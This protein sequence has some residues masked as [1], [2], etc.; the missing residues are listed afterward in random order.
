MSRQEYLD[1]VFRVLEIFFAFPSGV[2]ITSPLDEVLC[3]AMALSL[4]QYCF[5][6]VFFFAVDY[7]WWWFL[8]SWLL[9][10]RFVWTG[11]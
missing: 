11:L 5:D 4:V 8:R 3:S 1:K 2:V 10:E 7:L 6:K 9:W